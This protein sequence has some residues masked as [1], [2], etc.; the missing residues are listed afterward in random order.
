MSGEAILAAIE[1]A[2]E[3]AITKLRAETEARVRQALA[4]TEQV[5]AARR[6]AAHQSA[7]APIPGEQAQLL[8]QAR[9]DSMRLVGEVRSQRVAA[10]LEDVRRRLAEARTDLGYAAISRRLV[11]EAL[12]AL[13]ADE[14]AA[15]PPC[16]QADPR[17]ERLLRHL[18]DDLGY[19]LPIQATLRCWGGVVVRSGDE[20]ITVTN[21]LE[22]RFERALPHLRRELAAFLESEMQAHKETTELVV[23]DPTPGFP[24]VP[25]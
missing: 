19:R 20:R 16:L 18:L 15:H 12:Q 5:A 10:A 17:D 1:A 6:E 22:A 23:T 24:L 21:T 3:D 4:N 7:L 2:G 9:L 14:I 8:H 25:V 13:G 11:V